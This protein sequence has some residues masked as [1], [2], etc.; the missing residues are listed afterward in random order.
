[1]PAR[2]VRV[3]PEGSALR[4]DPV[5]THPVGRLLTRRPN[6]WQTPYEFIEGMVFTAALAGNAIA[7]KS[8]VGTEIRELLPVPAGAWTVQEVTDWSYSI[9]VTLARGGTMTFLPDQVFHL[10]RE[11]LG[12]QVAQVRGDMG[13]WRVDPA[14][15]ALVLHGGAEMPLQFEVIGPTELRLLDFE[16]QPIDSELDYSLRT[17]GNLT[18]TDLEL[19]FGGELQYMA[20]A[21]VFT[22]CLTGRRYPV[23]ME[24]DWIQA[25]R[26]YL[27]AAPEP[28]G[29]LYTTFEGQLTDRPKMEGEG[30]ER[31]LVVQ[32]FINVWPGQSCPRSLAQAELLETYWRIVRLADEPVRTAEQRREPHLILRREDNR[33]SATV[34]CNR[35]M[36]GYELEDGSLRFSGTASTRMACP[37]PLDA[38]E[39]ALAE[40]LDRTRRFRIVS[41]TLELYDEAG[42]SL[43]SLEAV[44]LR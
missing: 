28:R 2:V 13:R 19:F 35:M 24:G 4:T 27:E 42:R 10:R 9:R 22:E 25:E 20:D 34:G 39:R 18:P 23:A 5:W 30:T 3:T 6:G 21:A 12:K 43:A 32:R 7:I 26:A 14:R 17:D 8:M 37:P 11:W 44:Y 16:G 1:M 40:V 36:G 31:S 15:R 41:Q 38:W 33:F 29:R